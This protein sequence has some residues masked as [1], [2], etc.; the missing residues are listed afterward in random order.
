MLRQHQTEAATVLADPSDPRRYLGDEPG[1]GKTRTAIAALDKQGAFRPLVI[2]P[3]IVRSHWMREFSAMGWDHAADDVFIKSYDEIVRGGFPLMKA[4]VDAGIDAL[5]VDE[6][7][8]CKHATSQ[9]TNLVLGGNGY[10]RR[11]PFVILASGTPMPRNP[12]EFAPVLLSVFPKV[13]KE[14]GVDTLQRFKDR[15]CVVRSSWARGVKWEKIVDVKNVE[16]L[17][18]ML[19]Q[20]MIRRTLDQLGLD[21]PEM[22]IQVTRL[23][24]QD[25]GGVIREMH[26]ALAPHEGEEWSVILERIAND[27]QVARMRRR[28][29]ELKVGPVAEMVTSQLAD[30]GEKVCVFAYHR[31]VLQ[32]LKELFKS[33]NVAYIDGDVAG[34]ARDAEI[35]RFAKD[36]KCRVFLGQNIACQTGTDGLQYSGA[37]RVILV[38]PEWMADV[39]YQLG[40]RLARMGADSSRRVIVQ[41]IALAGTLDEAIVGQNARETRMVNKVIA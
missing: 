41:M 12:Y 24:A 8:Y 30:S 13:A 3:A 9:R 22:D 11:L 29:G 19:D 34:P 7:H 14:F 32:G 4:V 20:V 31:S 16:E 38:E 27:P 36:P 21:V 37:R 35:E 18:V 39:N 23:D 17:K 10:A 2:C 28:L 5:V 15:F 1:L 6:A 26:T 25:L 40:K 33:F